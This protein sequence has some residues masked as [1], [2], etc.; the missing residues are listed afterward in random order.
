MGTKTYDSQ[1][2]FIL[3]LSDEAVYL[4]DRWLSRNLMAST[5]VWLPLTVDGINITMPDR[6]S[7][8][9]NV[10]KGT[11]SFAPPETA[12][13]AET[14]TISNGAV[15]LNCSGCSSGKSVGYLGGPNDGTLTFTNI[16]STV[17]TRTTI[18]IE[19]ENGGKTQRLANVTVNGVTQELAFLPTA[20]ATTPG[21]STLHCDLVAG[22]N[23]IVIQGIGDGSYAADVDRLLVPVY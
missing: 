3:P 11:W 21:A 10:C 18:Q 13:E 19:F 12:P 17:T 1:T 5:Y 22:A 20:N 7:W 16:S 8:V 2:N 23:E 14:Q 4:G 15:V 9:P 6:E